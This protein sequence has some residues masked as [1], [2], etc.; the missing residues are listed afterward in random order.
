MKNREATRK[1][2]LSGK[3]SQECNRISAARNRHPNAGLFR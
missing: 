1:L 2:R 3:R